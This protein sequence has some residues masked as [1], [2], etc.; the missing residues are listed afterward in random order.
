[1]NRSLFITYLLTLAV[2]MVTP[3]PDML[4]CLASGLRGGPRSGFLAATGAATGEVVHISSAAVGLAALF[5][6]A[7][8][9]FHTVRLLGAAYLLLLGIRAFR[10]RNQGVGG[11]NGA[12]GSANRAYWRGLLT[13]LLNPK[14]ALFTIA[15]LPQFTDPQAGNLALQFLILG[16]CFVALEIAV[17][18]TVGILAG[19]L[20]RLLRARKARRNLNLTAG[21]IYL[22][23]GAKLALQRSV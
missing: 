1:M 14:M 12:A 2:L 17:D 10:H 6:A 13:N 22:G 11:G 9:L 16:A 5:R 4:F 19:R 18:G 3:G 15:L 8:L 23:L 7:P 20:A 21:S